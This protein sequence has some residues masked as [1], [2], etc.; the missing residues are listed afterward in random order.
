MDG[1]DYASE[2]AELLRATDPDAVK[3]LIVFIRE[4]AKHN[5]RKDVRRLRLVGRADE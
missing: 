3:E 1:E 5:P 2:A 4:W